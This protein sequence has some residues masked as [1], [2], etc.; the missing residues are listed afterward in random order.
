MRGASDTNASTMASREKLALTSA[1]GSIFKRCSGLGLGAP[2][3]KSRDSSRDDLDA[4][5][6]WDE[7]NAILDMPSTPSAPRRISPMAA[8]PKRHPR[9]QPAGLGLGL[10]P[11]ISFRTTSRLVSSL[12]SRWE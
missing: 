12:W 10:P 4:S 9:K 3:M 8:E 2:P 7:D 5:P 1:S 6:R 11:S